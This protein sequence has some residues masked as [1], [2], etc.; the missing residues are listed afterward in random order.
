MQGDG[1]VSNSGGEWAATPASLVLRVVATIVDWFILLFSSAFL[2][3]LPES[4]LQQED[5][6]L[7]ITMVASFIYYVFFE[8]TFGATPG[9]MLLGLKVVRSDGERIGYKEALIRTVMRLIDLLPAFYI[10]GVISILLSSRNQRLGDRVAGTLV[11]KGLWL[12]FGKKTEP[13]QKI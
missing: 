1:S 7:S 2:S 4:T 9:K 12:K 6:I 8:G 11:V 5:T 10:A 13:V 3:V